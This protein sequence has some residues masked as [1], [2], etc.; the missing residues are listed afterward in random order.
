MLEAVPYSCQDKVSKLMRSFE[1]NRLEMRKEVLSLRSTIR[2]N[3][4]LPYTNRGTESK[5]FVD[6][7]KQL[8]Q[9]R[10]LQRQLNKQK[11][12]LSKAAKALYSQR[13]SKISK[14]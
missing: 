1:Q 4:G 3:P 2:E 7:D 11:N 13:N 5:V 9:I 10:Q 14:S 8:N 12:L 6:V